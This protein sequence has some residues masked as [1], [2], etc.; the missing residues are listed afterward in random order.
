MEGDETA[1]HVAFNQYRDKIYAI[2]YTILRD[3]A[4]AERI[5]LCVFEDVWRCRETLPGAYGFNA[6]IDILLCK[7]L[8]AVCEEGGETMWLEK[9]L[10]EKN[11]ANL[12]S[13][14]AIKIDKERAEE[15]YSHL[16]K[17][18][19]WKVAGTRWK[20]LL[21]AALITG[22]VAVGVVW[23]NNYYRAF[24]TYITRKG[25]RKTF[26]LPDGTKVRLNSGSTLRL[27]GGYGSNRR[28]MELKGEGY[29][30]VKR[31][32]A[33][34]FVVHTAA[35]NI[36]DACA[37]F[38]V[39]A[40]PHEKA[41]MATAIGGKVNVTLK[42]KRNATTYR[43]APMQKLTVAK[44]AYSEGEAK[45]NQPRIEVLDTSQQT[46]APREISWMMSE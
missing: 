7:Y 31:D 13:M 45:P 20:L 35:M 4:A 16:Q 40:Y 46:S 9:Q 17:T 11:G 33:H 42:D 39:R 43:V 28:E 32:T 41:D 26:I 24:H 22:V 10:W 1:F 19:A 5:L 34:K 29:F 8:H 36:Q 44:P 12:A 2:L 27:A 3:Q 21:M 25:E 23:F 30:E 37:A 38:S 15:L 14:Q 18:L 6:Y